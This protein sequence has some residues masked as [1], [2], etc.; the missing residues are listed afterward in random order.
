MSRQL[1]G[2]I[3]IAQRDLPEFHSFIKRRDRECPIQRRPDVPKALFSLL[4]NAGSPQLT[5]AKMPD[6][7]LQYR[8]A[9]TFNSLRPVP[10]GSQGAPAPRAL[11]A[12][13]RAPAAS[14][15][16]E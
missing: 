7:A 5:A 3:R 10:E 12:A 15:D 6:G 2:K 9:G 14:D 13:P 8:L 1:D 11:P 16:E 4:D